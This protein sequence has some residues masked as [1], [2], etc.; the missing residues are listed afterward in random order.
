M[1]DVS[2]ISKYVVLLC[3]YVFKI[4][5]FMQDKQQKSPQRQRKNTGIISKKN[6][7]FKQYSCFFV[8]FPGLIICTFK[9][10]CVSK[11]GGVCKKK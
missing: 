5:H 11:E 1:Q 2:T 3:V 4:I 7:N 6:V 10:M 8:L 9:K